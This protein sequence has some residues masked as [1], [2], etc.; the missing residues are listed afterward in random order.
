[1]NSMGLNPWE[2]ASC[3]ATEELPNILWN[4]KVQ[5]HARTSPPVVP[6]LSQV[7]TVYNT[8]TCFCIICF[9]IISPHLKCF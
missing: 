4:L 5:Y 8:L 2:A 6:I 3:L 1:M 9:D 7:N